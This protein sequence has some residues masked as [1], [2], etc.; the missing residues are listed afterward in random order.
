MFQIRLARDLLNGLV[1]HHESIVIVPRRFFQS[2]Q[3]D[4]DLVFYKLESIM[5]ATDA[6][7]VLK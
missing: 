2:F 6:S 3:N 4:I 5:C 7:K 1:I